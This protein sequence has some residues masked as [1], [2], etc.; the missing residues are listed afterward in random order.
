MSVFLSTVRFMTAKQKK[1]GVE[2][3]TDEANLSERERGMQWEN[4]RPRVK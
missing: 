3:A 2:N 4:E 1:G